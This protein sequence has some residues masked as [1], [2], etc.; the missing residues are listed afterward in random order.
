MKEKVNT[1]VHSMFMDLQIYKKI[2]STVKRQK[3][4]VSKLYGWDER[5]SG[6][7]FQG[8]EIKGQVDE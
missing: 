8:E 4:I 7:F 3:S 5:F 2:Q 6:I 1:L